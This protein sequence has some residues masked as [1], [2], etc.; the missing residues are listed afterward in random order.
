MTDQKKFQS[1][2]EI[3]KDEFVRLQLFWIRASPPS[4]SGW[5]NNRG[6]IAEVGL[7]SSERVGEIEWNYRWRVGSLP[8]RSS[9]THLG[10][11]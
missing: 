10:F 1:S 6:I 4:H 11:P 2:Q 7:G 9:H 8:F 5:E 3:R